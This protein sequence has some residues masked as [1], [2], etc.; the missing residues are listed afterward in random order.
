MLGDG[1]AQGAGRL[2]VDDEVDP[3]SLLDGQVGRAR[4][5]HFLIRT[6]DPA[7]D[8]TP[9][10]WH[11]PRCGLADGWD[12]AP[13]HRRVWVEASCPACDCDYRVRVTQLVVGTPYCLVVHAEH[14]VVY[15][16]RR[17]AQTG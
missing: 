16:D 3:H 5:L 11:C 7:M 1:E 17:D 8:T 10:Y 2:Q 15:T 14:G 12:V 9:V 13:A 4:P 6:R